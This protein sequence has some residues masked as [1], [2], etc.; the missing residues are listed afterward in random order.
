MEIRTLKD[1]SDWP[2]V[3]CPFAG[4]KQKQTQRESPS[5][6]EA[7]AWVATLSLHAATSAY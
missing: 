2:E 5:A 4:I 3:K 6:L 7:V 1:T